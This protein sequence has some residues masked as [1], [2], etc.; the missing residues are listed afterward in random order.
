MGKKLDQYLSMI[1]YIR[2]VEA[3]L[4]ERIKSGNDDIKFSW[5]SDGEIPRPN[6][7]RSI[8]HE[9]DGSQTFTFQFGRDK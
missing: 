1:N 7:D 6:E 9:P 8:S 3:L 2:Q 4:T 5:T